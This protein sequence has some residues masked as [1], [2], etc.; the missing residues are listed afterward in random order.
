[1]AALCAQDSTC[2]VNAAKLFENLFVEAL[3]DES[4]FVREAAVDGL[5]YINKTNALKLL[6]SDFINDPSIALRKK[7]IAFA[8]E[9]GGKEDLNW[10]SEKIG[11]NSESDPAWQAMLKIF[12]GSD[13]G[14]LNE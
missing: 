9:V 2:K 7:I 13:A 8:D 14:V 4:N 1:M 6:R 3:R 10:L 5:G 11:L 12:R